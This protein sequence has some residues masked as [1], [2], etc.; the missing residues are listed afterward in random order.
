MKELIKRIPILRSIAS[1]VYFTF[2]KPFKAFPGSEEYW[3]QRYKAGGNSGTGS[4]NELAKFKAQVLNSI[5]KENQINTIIEFGC[6]DGNQ[7][8]LAKY[9]SY[10]GFDV[11]PE[12]IMQCQRIFSNDKTK[13][14]KLMQEYAN[15]TAE[16]TLSIDVIYHLIE[17]SIF[18]DYMERLFDSSMRFVIIFSSN[19]QKQARFQAPHVKHRQFSKWIEDNRPEWNLVKHIPN[20]YPYTGGDGSLADFYV[21]E[22]T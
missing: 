22:K 17:D 18:V 9:P 21:Y 13:T 12:A 14:F 19:T 15:E 2:V 6:G 1:V 11:S 4:Y 10:L 16:L 20:K 8:R 3:K 5:V 7:F